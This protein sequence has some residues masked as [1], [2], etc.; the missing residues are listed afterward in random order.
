MKRVAE[1]FRL[2]GRVMLVTGGAG[3][4][5]LAMAEALAEFGAHIVIADRAQ[6]A[7]D[8]RAQDIASRFQVQALGVAEDLGD[9]QA[10]SRI[11]K[12]VTDHFQRL[13][14]VIHNAAF[15]GA[16][17]LA[18][19]A[20]PFDEQSIEAWDAAVRV[21]MSAGFGLAQSARS[22]LDQSGHGV[23][24]NVG[25]IYGVT[26][27]NMNLYTGTKMGNPAAY[28]ASK[29]GLVQLTKYMSTVLAPKIRV[30][31]ISPGGI[32][33]GQPEAFQ[34]RYSALTPLGRMGTEQDLKAVTAF[35]CSDASA[36]ITGQ[37][38]MVD[39]GWTVW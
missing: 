17:G 16:S 19:Y 22:W 31:A 8:Q 9:P 10:P 36:Y 34:S 29:A 18:G 39:G 1:L 24:V 15:T 30:N 37:N 4:I 21:N 12:R 38:I 2:D 35:L 32:E 28:A 20:V 27:P 11:V 6:D 25:S 33:R 3:H 23:I 7:C 5:G 13:D 14:G 26:A